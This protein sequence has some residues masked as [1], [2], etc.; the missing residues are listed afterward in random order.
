MKITLALYMSLKKIIFFPAK[1]QFKLRV[2]EMPELVTIQLCQNVEIAASMLTEGLAK[3]LDE[4]APIAEG[5]HPQENAPPEDRQLA[6]GEPML[7]M[8][9]AQ[10]AAGGEAP[11]L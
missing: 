2:G 6:E 11:M 7:A 10:M 3:I 8:N 4:M 5:I 9:A 1:E